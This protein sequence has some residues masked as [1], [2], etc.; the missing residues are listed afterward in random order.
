MRRSRYTSWSHTGT[1]PV[2][3]LAPCSI[4]DTQADLVSVPVAGTQAGL[5]MCSMAGTQ[6]GLA[7][8]P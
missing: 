8:T 1:V 6:A 3:G 7:R 5:I 4:A 2:A